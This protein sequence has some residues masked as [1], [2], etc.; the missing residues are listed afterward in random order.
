MNAALLFTDIVDST[1]LQHRHGDAVMTTVWAAHDEQARALIRRCGGREVGRSDGFLV[2]FEQVADALAFAHAYHAALGALQVPLSARVG[3]HYGPVQLR[4]NSADATA[5]GATRYDVDG[6]A[7]PLAA[8]VM[9]AAVGGQTLLSAAAAE[10]ARAATPL[11]L[12][13]HGHWRLKG[14]E[15]PM[16]IFQAGDEG[17]AF[18]P[19]PDTDKAHRVVQVGGLWQPR[20]QLPHSLPAER[21]VFVGRGH[22]LQVLAQRFDAGARLITLLGIGGIGKTRL[23]LH[24]AR[25]WLGEH[26]GGSWFCDLSATRSV[27]G[28]LQAVAAGLGLPPSAGDPAQLVGRAIAGR[29]PC[30][31]VIDNAEQ[32]RE[33][34]ARLIGSW[35]DAA[36]QARFLVTTR[37]MLGMVGEQVLDLDPLPAADSATLFRRRAEAVLASFDPV[38]ADAEAIAPLMQLLDG[39]PLAIE[40]AAARVRVMSP[41][42]L[43]QRMGDRFRVLR[44]GGGRPDRQATLRGAIDWSWDLLGAAEKAALAQLSVFAGGFTLDA[45]EAVLDLTPLDDAWVADRV[46]ALVE[47]SL[48]R[49][50]SDTRLALLSS[51]QAYAAEQLATPGRWPGSGPAARQA[52]LSRHAAYFAA[53]AE[54][55]AVA[56]G[57]VEVDNLVQAC[58]HAAGTG[59]A[60]TA[61][62]ALVGVWAVLR[63]VGPFRAALELAA[64][65]EPVVGAD[66]DSAA[67]MH[68]VAASAL[69][70]LG[71]DMPSRAHLDA[72]LS[73]RG[74]GPR[75]RARLQC[76]L[77]EVLTTAGDGDAAAA[78]LTQALDAARTLGDA[79]LECRALN[80]LG[81]LAG[82][83]SRLDEAARC[84]EQALAV[85]RRVGD[86]RWQ[87]G[88]L[89]NLGC[90]AQAQGQAA[91]A[92][93]RFEQALALAQQTGDRR[94]ECSARNNL[95]LMHHEAG[96]Q[97]LART[98]LESGLA[99][100]RAIGARAHEAVLLCNLGL[101]C[102]AEGDPT[103]ACRLQEESVQLARALGDPRSEGQ[104]STD[105]A[106]SYS[107]LGRRADA[108]AMF[109]IAEQ[110]LGAV[111][112]RLSL[113]L[114]ACR[115]VDCELDWG[116]G[117]A[118]AARLQALREQL[119]AEPL[120][121][122]AG[123]RPLLG[124][125]Q[126]RLAPPFSSG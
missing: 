108:E 120:D 51:V 20:R 70:Q 53:L 102:A 37:E 14:V 56:G 34:A 27:D 74:A 43:L 13:S 50:V 45:A 67:A 11:R 78:Q 31:V 35:L 54:S 118:A 100:A 19:P 107:A 90:V 64:E 46:Q 36:P 7:L 121:D 103:A 94:W 61:A 8:R 66:D 16:E 89:G 60:A 33:D 87:G 82:D 80:E 105:L 85:A 1:R 26:P 117:A 4:E 81:A 99:T 115:R 2:L 48:V 65:V 104:L 58:R 3:L 12:H 86:G 17:S 47:K 111:G 42:V 22:A 6:L 63:G 15:E 5:L 21:D 49:R 24:Y 83:R 72:G 29:G 84:Y 124:Q 39:L 122:D 109:D 125:V 98:H 123:L 68:W 73:L 93:E 38:G 92:L 10:Q 113:A 96:A 9:S 91:L 71:E 88:L 119:Q 112:D 40:L 52:A 23:A 75:N 32:V 114:L 106:R 77:G 62:A 55:Q 69:R 126:A 18:V 79:L 110:R 59:D 25:C 95:G 28:L 41:G 30:L 57:G 116:D 44:A 76:A 101:V 97:A